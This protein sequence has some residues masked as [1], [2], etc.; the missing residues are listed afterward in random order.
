LTTTKIKTKLYSTVYQKEVDMPFLVSSPRSRATPSLLA[1]GGIS[2]LV[3]LGGCAQFPAL[4]AFAVLKP[5]SGY[6]T[7]SSFSGHA[8]AWP[9]E[10]WWQAYGD[11]QLDD[12]DF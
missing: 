9:A 2:L 10:R 6:E 12:A 4:D 3:G 8:T 11:P 5:A 1:V 7:S